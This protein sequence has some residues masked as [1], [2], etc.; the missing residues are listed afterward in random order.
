MVPLKLECP[1][2]FQYSF[3]RHS[4]TV[5]ISIVSH[6]A[7]CMALWCSI[8]ALWLLLVAV[9]YSLLGLTYTSHPSSSSHPL[10]PHYAG[11]KLV[12]S[13]KNCLKT[14]ETWPV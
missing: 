3:L 14:P 2:N 6:L 11:L 10:A 12:A 9:H 5:P 13:R 4:G 1:P 8:N 7:P